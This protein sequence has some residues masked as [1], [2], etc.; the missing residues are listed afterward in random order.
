MLHNILA[1]A[2]ELILVIV[3]K[4]NQIVQ[5][6]MYCELSAFPNLALVCL[7][8]A[9]KDEYV[10]VAAV[11]LV[12]KRCAG[13]GGHALTERAGGQVNAGGLGAVGMGREV[14]VR[15]VERIRILQRI[16]TLQAEGSVHC[17][18]GMSLG[19][20]A[21]VTILPAGVLRINLHYFTIQ[22]GQRGQ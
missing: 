17:R 7:A 11:D 12:A 14:G 1:C 15:L 19:Q 6:I 3:D 20:Y 21:P 22:N 16:E 4:A 5:L 10:V 8:V 2:V 13:C 9:D 18:A